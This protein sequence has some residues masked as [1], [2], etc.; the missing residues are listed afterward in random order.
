MTDLNDFAQSRIRP[1]G[2]LA[3]HAKD[4]ITLREMGLTLGDIQEFLASKE[5]QVT[6][7][8]LSQFFAK[9]KKNYE[10]KEVRVVQQISAGN[11]LQDGVQKTNPVKRIF[12]EKQ[13][14]QTSDNQ[15]TPAWLPEDSSN[16]ADDLY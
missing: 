16:L 11:S 3:P 5:V 7:P 8:A 13:T 10:K 2:K 6:I 15:V 9:T 14:G 12:S 4:I 1:R